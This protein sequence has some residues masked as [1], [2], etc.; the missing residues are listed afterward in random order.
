M[1][2]KEGEHKVGY[3]SPPL[4]SRFEK[5]KSGN[6]GG[7]RRRPAVTSA[8]S[9]LVN[10]L[11]RRVIVKNDAD[12][13]EERKS[14]LEVLMDELVKKAREGDSRCLK[15]VMDRL[16]AMSPR[17][18]DTLERRCLDELALEEKQEK[19][20]RRAAA[21]GEPPLEPDK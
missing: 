19:A 21:M 6:P 7:K 5:G 4:H 11:A 20:Q 18:E 13:G 15:L 17:G 10:A 12:D 8:H 14:Q 9:A 1:E 16:D 2:E 3:R